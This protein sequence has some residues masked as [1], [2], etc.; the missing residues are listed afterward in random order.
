MALT[1]VTGSVIKDSVSLSGNVS[2]GGTLTYED[3]TNV[4]SVGI[5]TARNGVDASGTSIF[6]GPL[7]AQDNLE[8]AGELVHLSDNNTRIRFPANDT[9]SFQTAGSERF[10]IDHD[11]H[12]TVGVGASSLYNTYLTIPRYTVDGD[13]ANFISLRNDAA[14]ADVTFVKSRSTTY[15]SYAVIQDDD[16][17]MSINSKID[18]GS[19]LSLRGTF[20]SIYDSATNGV[21]F[22]WGSGGAPTTTG[23]KMRLTA[24][25]NLGI[26]T[27]SPT[28]KLEVVDS[29]YHQLYLKGSGTVGGIRLGN[30][31]N[32]NGF[33]YYDNGPNLLF[34]VNNSEKVRITSSGNLLI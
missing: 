1:K 12:I 26:N 13:A 7:Q 29:A 23:E 6:R 4:D 3:V 18:T 17:I 14:P 20:R 33:I 31:G 16:I 22:M 28:A 11:G 32:Q 24:T 27:V 30:S 8:M 15:G 25:G 5:V 19:A 21:H 9:I 10:R 34:N 2:I